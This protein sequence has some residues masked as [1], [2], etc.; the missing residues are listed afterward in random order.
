MDLWMRMGSLQLTS[1]PY[2][3][4][5]PC[6]PYVS[7]TSWFLSKSTFAQENMGSSAYIYVKDKYSKVTWPFWEWTTLW[8]GQSRF[9]SQ[10]MAWQYCSQYWSYVMG[11]H[12]VFG[13]KFDQCEQCQHGNVKTYSDFML[14]RVSLCLFVVY[15][16]RS[17]D[18][19]FTDST[20]H[21]C[22]NSNL[23]RMNMLRLKIQLIWL[24]LKDVLPPKHT[25]HH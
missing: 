8:K 21:S 9:N 10:K 12:G 15:P 23:Y 24:Y 16:Y 4:G 5:V 2:W 13:I 14:L 6:L 3:T 1:I 17:I 22:V 20:T 19:G 7:I 11:L 25:V 18:L